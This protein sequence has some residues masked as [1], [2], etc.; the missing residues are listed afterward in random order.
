MLPVG[1]VTPAQEI[2]ARGL[3]ENVLFRVLP[4]IGHKLTVGQVQ[5]LAR[6]LRREG[7]SVPENPREAA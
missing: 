7:V 3:L 1:Q 2:E 5:F 6:E 4:R